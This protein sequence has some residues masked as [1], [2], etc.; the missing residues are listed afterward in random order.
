[1]ITIL[2]YL[3]EALI[4]LSLLMMLGF[5]LR[6]LIGGRK[7]YIAIGAF[8]LAL[9]VFVILYLVWDAGQYAPLRGNPV[10]Q[11]EAAIVL[12]AVVMFSLGILALLVSAV[13]GLIK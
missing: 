9:L 7:N 2:V 13:R 10:T 5:G 6:T 4:V 1:M 3:C 8:G 11:G 12:T